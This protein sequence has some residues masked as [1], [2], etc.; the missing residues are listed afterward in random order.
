[1][2]VLPL[3]VRSFMTSAGFHLAEAVCDM[4]LGTL[5]GAVDAGFLAGSTD[6]CGD[7]LSR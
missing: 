5:P 7:V 1:M 6:L 2:A 4:H 3:Q